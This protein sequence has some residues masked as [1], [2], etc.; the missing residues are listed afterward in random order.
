MI[1]N[2]TTHVAHIV[3]LDPVRVFNNPLAIRLITYVYNIVRIMLL[4]CSKVQQ[5]FK[6]LYYILKCL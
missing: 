4:K 5:P 1:N 6:T 2:N 3:L